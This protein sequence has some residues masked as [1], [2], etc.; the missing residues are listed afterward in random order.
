MDGRGSWSFSLIRDMKNASNHIIR[1][2]L[3][4]IMRDKYPKSRH[5][6]LVLP[7]NDIDTVYQLTRKDIPLLEEMHLLGTNAIEL[8]RGQA[9]D[10][11]IGF[12]MKPSMHRL[13]L[14]V[15]SKDFV[16][17]RLKHKLHWNSFHTSF[18]MPFECILAE[19]EERGQ[20][21]HR[22]EQ[23]IDN[24][25]KTPLACHRCDR[26]FTTMPALKKHLEGHLESF[27]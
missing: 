3:A 19:L 5:H 1:S 20:I 11:K 22:P 12:H 9:D 26:K 27:S 18:F 14:H 8:S 2:D 4:V 7:W 25:L 23:Y 6:F 17:D 16:S 13:H 24:L 21:E 15:I 10:F